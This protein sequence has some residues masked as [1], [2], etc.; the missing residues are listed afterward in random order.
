MPLIEEV[1]PTAVF[2]TTLDGEQ[3]VGARFQLAAPRASQSKEN[4]PHPARQAL[5]ASDEFLI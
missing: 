4:G 2:G 5:F 1:G 3:R